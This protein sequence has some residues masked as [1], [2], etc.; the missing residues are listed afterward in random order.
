M[1]KQN[2]MDYYWSNKLI[3]LRQNKNSTRIQL[4]RFRTLSHMSGTFAYLLILVL[5][6]SIAGSAE[7]R[8]SATEDPLCT[9]VNETIQGLQGQGRYSPYTDPKD[10]RYIS[11]ERFTVT[12]VVTVV[13]SGIEKGIFIQQTSAVKNEAN[14]T[15][16]K[17]QIEHRLTD[18]DLQDR[19]ASSGIFVAYENRTNSIKPGDRVCVQGKVE[20]DYGMTQLVNADVRVIGSSAAPMALPLL[21]R[22]DESFAETLERHE[23][24]FVRLTPQSDMRISR[25]FGYDRKGYRNNMV[26]THR[27]INM[28]PNQHA[29]PGSIWAERKAS[30]NARR[31]LFVETDLKARAGEIPYYPDFGKTSQHHLRVNDRISG[32]EGVLTYS[33]RDYRLIVIN[34]ITKRDIQTINVRK[35]QPKLKQGDLRIATF[36]VLNY[37][38]SPY[39]GDLNPSRKNR[40]AESLAE[41]KLQ[42]Q[43]LV[44]AIHAMDADLIGLTEIENNGFDSNGAIQRLLRALNR[45]AVTKFDLYS[46]VRPPRSEL[47]RGRFVGTD[48]IS[49]AIIYRSAKLTLQKA[50]VLRMP[51]QQSLHQKKYHRDPIIAT[52][53]VKGRTTPLTVAVNHFKSK[54][55]PCWEDKHTKPERDNQANCAE[56]RVSAALVLGDELS[57]IE[58]D[59]LII[60]DLNSYPKE[61]PLLVMTDYSPLKY[62]FYP[63]EVSN[64]T[65]IKGKKLQR[66]VKTGFGYLNP[67]AH[68]EASNNSQNWTYSYEGVGTL[69]YILISPGLSDYVLD[70]TVWHINAAESPLFQYRRKYTGDMVKFPDLYRSSDHDPVL[71]ELKF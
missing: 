51:V 69:D 30:E 6:L 38:N 19:R 7:G 27:Q 2:S 31:R 53:R 46:V 17:Q 18:L 28:H 33:Y 10:K 68:G 56:F 59:K 8:E 55:S 52:F 25:P 26:L 41:F 5:L 29:F 67:F 62:A 22:G 49:V 16:T 58:G 63:I 24:M 50:R 44:A 40:G 20:E 3:R 42:E 13:T 21:P 1:L 32:L 71:L 45:K 12:G 35:E 36:N 14:N 64:H 70:S 48:A 37:F 66:N 4:W 11:K 57:K 9:G 61:D 43:K 23:G 34:T 47:Y 54:G 60:G 65:S 15:S 39:G